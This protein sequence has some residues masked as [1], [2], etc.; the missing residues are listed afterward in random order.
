MVESPNQQTAQETQV[1][2]SSLIER[3]HSALLELP[4]FMDQATEAFWHGKNS[5][6]IK[7][8][9][10]S[11]NVEPIGS[12]RNPG[13][14]L[15]LSKRVSIGGKEGS[16]FDREAIF[17][18]ASE[19]RQS[20]SY[21][22]FPVFG[23]PDATKALQGINGFLSE[24][25]A[26]GSNNEQIEYPSNPNMLTPDTRERYGTDAQV[27][28]VFD[29]VPELLFTAPMYPYVREGASRAFLQKNVSFVIETG[30]GALRVFREH[31]VD[32]HGNYHRADPFKVRT[33]LVFT[34]SRGRR[35]ELG[36]GQDGSVFTGVRYEEGA[37]GSRDRQISRSVTEGIEQANNFLDS[38][39]QLSH[40]VTNPQEQV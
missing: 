9:N 29:R 24:I 36:I 38:L 22:K 31:N 28:Q 40:Q 10:K 23:E 34:P 39:K 37:E 1:N 2:V 14:K 21:R 7:F 27:Q 4:G 17:Q 13:V 16:D 6:N 19:Q 3:A 18:P 11:L 33:G 12:I 8:G 25:E 5:V 30:D 32:T 26:A 15:L 20:I 35:R